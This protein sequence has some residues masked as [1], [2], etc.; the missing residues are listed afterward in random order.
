MKLASRIHII[1]TLL[2][3]GVAVAFVPASVLLHQ[4]RGPF[5]AVCMAS[6]K[7][8]EGG[9]SSTTTTTTTS[10][11]VQS[12]LDKAARIRAEIA[13]LEGKTIEQVEN[14]ASAKKQRQATAVEASRKARIEHDAKNPRDYGR[15]LQVPTSID[16]MIQ[17]AARAMER[18]FHDGGL[19]RQTVRLAL[20]KYDKFTSFLDEEQWPGGAEQMYREAA[21]PLTYDLLRELR[22][23]KDQIRPLTVSDQDIWDFDGS[24]LITGR[25]QSTEQQGGPAASDDV[26]QSL[27]FANTDEKYINDIEKIDAAMGKDRLFCLVNPFW[28]GIESWGI[29]I[30]APNA[31]KRA[32]Q[33]IFDNDN[34]SNNRKK[35][36]ET[37]VFLRFACR[38]E[39]CVAIKAYPYDWQIFAYLEN[40][41]ENRINN[42]PTV[43][44]LGSTK[45]EPKSQYV[46]E[47]IN[48]LPE[49]KLSKTMRQLRR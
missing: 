46:T 9:S 39:D 2:L 3:L 4:Q 19:T 17:Q 45:E 29:N 49:F 10:T 1:L 33:V 40:N 22:L 31:K 38:G 14:E 18:A 11:E 26:V 48:A 15:M 6:G 36:D 25:G 28:R 20:V 7:D 5:S 32:Q 23:S 21:K 43:I 41:N 16:D 44:R 12:L 37:Y 8:Q 27:V 13:A 47:L 42:S 35:F 34:N 30:L 24:G